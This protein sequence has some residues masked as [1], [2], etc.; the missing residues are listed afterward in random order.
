ML[1]DF[2]RH[3]EDRFRGSRDDIKDRLR[4][5][6]PFLES[7]R[8]I[9]KGAL[10]VLD[11]GCGRGE[12]L[13]LLCENGFDPMGVDLDDGMLAACRERQLKTACADAITFLKEVEDQSVAIVSAFHLV[14]HIEFSDL[15]I[16]V[17]EAERALKPGGLLI[18]ETPNPENILVGTSSFYLDPTHR[19]P[20]PPSLL[21]F[22]VQ[23][24]Q[25]YRSKVVRLQEA[26]NL[27]TNQTPSLH[28]VL[29]G[30]SPDYAVI[31]QKTSSPEI[32]SAADVCFNKD[33][34]L[35]L[36]TL[37]ARFHD[38][39]A[40]VEQLAIAAC[41]QISEARNTVEQYKQDYEAILKNIYES[42]SWRLTRP[43]RWLGNKLRAAR[44][45][46]VKQKT[47]TKLKNLGQKLVT[48]INSSPRL[49]KQLLQMARACG[50]YLPM[51]ALYLRLLGSSSA[52]YL[53]PNQ[54]SRK[55]H[56]TR[57]GSRAA[58]I[59]AELREGIAARDGKN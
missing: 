21:N 18:L 38:H 52:G 10:S 22:L 54:W 4:I 48:F 9:D 15:Q 46:S 20:I 29:S 43:V 19:R 17:S 24:A 59:Y 33:Y 45:L 8:G 31:G 36:D 6:L 57:M 51:K 50:V 27:R 23:T 30:V 5:Y 13:E 12:W 26:A 32:L 25:F 28:D 56:R 58:Q 1:N 42:T 40:K 53:S 37:A 7:V 41:A 3:F 44:R 35:S 49:R 39:A 2:Y 34:G 14:E 47:K 55:M 11:L 16:L